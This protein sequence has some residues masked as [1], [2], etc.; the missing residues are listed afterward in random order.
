MKRPLAIIPERAAAGLGGYEMLSGSSSFITLQP[1]SWPLPIKKHQGHF[2]VWITNVK[3]DD[4]LDAYRGAQYTTGIANPPA[5]VSVEER[6][7]IIR[8]HTGVYETIESAIARGVHIDSATLNLGLEAAG[9]AELEKQ[10][11]W[12]DRGMT[13]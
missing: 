8:S 4:P 6:E 11:G 13:I 12:S 5:E 1:M 10:Y 9:T 2:Y 3:A 7:R